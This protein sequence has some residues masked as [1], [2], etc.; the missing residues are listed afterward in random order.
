MPTLLISGTDTGVGKTLIT[1]ALASYLEVY[2]P[3]QSFAIF[4]PIQ[5]GLGDREHYAANFQL[6]QTLDQITPLYFQAPLAPPLAAA[7]ENKAIDLALAWSTFQSLQQTRDWMLVEGVGGLGTPITAELTVAD[8]ARDW[9]LP[10][11]LVVPVRL[12]AIGQAIAQVA[13]AR[14][15]AVPVKGFILSCP[16]PVSEEQIQQWA[17][18]DLLQSFTQ[19]PVLGVLPHLAGT[20]DK[21]ALAQLVS[22]WNLEVLLPDLYDVPKSWAKNR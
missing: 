16:D 12:G 14:Q 13:L 6:D 20:F 19:H 7:A 17:A 5:S 3:R 11:I 10:T 22:Q 2:R 15:T 1:S 4:K 18:P 21:S 9:R 8:L